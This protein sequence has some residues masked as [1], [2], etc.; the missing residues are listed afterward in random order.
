[1][2]GREL[3]DVWAPLT[4]TEG[5]GWVRWSRPAVFDVTYLGSAPSWP[6][7]PAPWPTPR[8]APAPDEGCAVVIDLPGPTS[9]AFGVALAQRGF[10][11][12]PVFTS[13]PPP[14]RIPATVNT[15][16]I[17]AALCEG[18]RVLQDLSLPTEAPPAFLLDHDRAQ[19]A[20][21]E[22]P[23]VFDNRSV[24]LPQDFPSANHLRAHGIRTVLFVLVEGEPLRNDVRHVLR[25]WQEGG[26]TLQLANPDG[27][28]RIGWKVPVPKG[29]R[30]LLHTLRAMWPFAPNH[31]GAFGEL[32]PLPPD[33]SSPTGFWGGVGGGFS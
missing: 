31:A 28:E 32:I 20:T 10:R 14:S 9:V 7:R 33:P 15:E 26:L 21:A 18:G 12:V 29:F 19:R 24:V 22:A 23:G 2:S 8:W 4:A 6:E 13:A 11:P 17:T 5:P 27:S 25:R 16:G 3:F 1:M 30:S